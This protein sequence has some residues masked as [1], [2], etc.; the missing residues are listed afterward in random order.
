MTPSHANKKGR[1]YRYYVSHSLVRA[2]GSRKSG[3]GRR[4][5]AGGIEQLVEGRVV[6]FLGDPASVHEA[7]GATEVSSIAGQRIVEDAH[8]LAASWSELTPDRKRAILCRLIDRV[9]ARPDTID[10]AV[11][12][13]V[14]ADVTAE[15]FE[16]IERAQATS[17]QAPIVLSIPARLKRV[18]METKLVL[19]G[20]PGRSPR[21]PDRSLLRLIAQ[22]HRYREIMMTA[23]GKTVAELAA[24]VGVGSSYY[25]RLVKLSFLSP[26]VIHAILRGRQ[27]L[28]LNAKR[29]AR[30]PAVP[31]NWADQKTLTGIV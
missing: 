25:T 7:L 20:P 14:I 11:R 28:E 8:A 21:E 4:I 17:D 13:T 16:P 6:S 1:R 24:S 26:D 23:Q 22:A 5:P 31:V 12:P 27:R 30:Y 19:D 18:G 2:G 9:I 15:T 10:V 3:T 29:L